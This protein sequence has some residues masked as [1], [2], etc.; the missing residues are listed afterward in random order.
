M[1]PID[2]QKWFSN[3]VIVADRFHAIRLVGLHLMRAARQL[4]PVLGWN[5]SWLGLLR[6]RTDRLDPEQRQRRVRLFSDHPVFE[7]ICALKDCICRVLALRTQYKVSCG[8]HMRSL[9]S[10]IEILRK[11]G[12]ESAVTLART[13]SDWT[14]E[15]V[16]MWRGTRNFGIQEDAERMA[17]VRSP[18]TASA[19]S[20]SA[21]NSNP[22]INLPSQ[23]SRPQSLE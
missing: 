3:A 22:T 23:P 11:D 7:D 8:H 13:L 6:R 1:L 14:H 21:V 4:C 18:I 15:I 16:R 17:S 12:L 2:D 9:F 10:F 19:S 20:L 5:R